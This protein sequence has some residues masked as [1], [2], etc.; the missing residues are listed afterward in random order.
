MLL[1]MCFCIGPSTGFNATA[2][3][4][5]VGVVLDLDTTLGKICK[6]CISMAIEDFYSNRD[7]NTMIEP[8]FRDSR[9]D[10]V[11]AASAAIDLLKN[12][13]VMAIIGP[14][15]SFQAEFVIDIGDKV[16][17]PIISPATSPSVSP[18]DSSYF[19]RSAWC[20]SSQVR[21]IAAIVKKFGWREVVFVYEDTNYGSGLVPYLT[22]DLLKSNAVVSHQS[23][24]P[25]NATE[26][27]IRQELFK[28][29]KM[30]T[31]VFV[32]HMLPGLASRFFN[33]AKEAG[34][35][36][37][38]YA[39]LIAD[40][41]TSLLD[42]MDPQTMEAMQG[43]LGV[44]A[45]VPE[46]V[47]LIDFKKRWRKRFHTE[48]PEMNRTELNVLG[49]WAYDS[50]AVLAEA[51][52][53]AGVTSPQFNRSVDSGNLTD[54][55][56]I[57][58]SLA[59]PSL[60]GWIRNHTSK[61]LSGDFNISNGELQPSA[62]EIVNVNGKKEIPVGFWT[63]HCGISRELKPDDHQDNCSTGNT[64]LDPI[65][66]PGKET[67]VPKGWE[68][69]VS[70]EKFRVGIPAKTSFRE[71]SVVEKNE[72]TGVVE[73]KGFCIDVF[74]AVWEK[75]PY[76]VPVEYVPYDTTDG[77]YNELSQKMDEEGL[78]ALVGDLTVTA[79]RS[80]HVDFTVPYTESGVAILV[81][82][83]ANE[84][85]NAWIFMKPLTTGLW[86]T[87]GTFFV[88]TG[89]VVWVLE[90]R[91]NKAFQGPPNQQVGM[92][93]WFSFSTLVFAHREKVTSN[94]TRFVVIIWVFV[95]L[96]LTSSYTA[97]LSSM[98]TVYQLQPKINDVNDLVKNGEFVGYQLGSFVRGFLTNNGILPSSSLKS[99]STVD[100]FHEALSKGSRNGG[101]GAV[102]DELPYIRL[103]LSK[104]CDK[105]TIIGPIYPTSG[106]GFAFP[107]G[108]PL[109]F[110][111]S[112]EILRLKEDK[113]LMMRITKKWLG[114]EKEC[115]NA[116]GALSTSQRLNLDSFKGLFVIAGVSS[117]L[118]LAIFLSHFLYE[119][120]YV[121]ESTVSRKEKLLGLARIFSREKDELLSPKETR[122][123]DCGVEQQ[124]V[125]P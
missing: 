37:K 77:G 105:Y 112:R 34:M 92:I 65:V 15:K 44:K 75:I 121:L 33:V 116:D 79:S 50:I 83:R 95:V 3:K 43:V 52:E 11:T 61:G 21:A 81:P 120:R 70:G 110:D 99:Y 80:E 16:E 104:H 58:T 48:N 91:V 45:Y 7:Y 66:W 87:I 106:L 111:V 39:W 57:G 72:E 1:F 82:I 64:N 23:V 74:E 125:Q 119:N 122:C 2:A 90:H 63:E 4:A 8:H 115:P 107:K 69:A 102:I 67:K 88:Y 109:V 56:S 68:I 85:K 42:S 14:Q 29:M 17:V 28:L 10:L 22:V 84:G 19:I 114:D 6:T 38:G 93:F 98:L 30:R 18:K 123:P 53:R 101:V 49:L 124:Q 5:N 55:D 26:D 108:S 24:I 54:L 62:F 96:V 51:I 97:N 86:L 32:V 35:M 89:F 117:T 9:S 94:L 20:S 31:R 27:R 25:A 46:S 103:L 118:A 13:E 12:A 59:G 36:D 76:H 40:V 47:K 71:F 113:D 100:Q 41:L 73:A 78:D 60:V